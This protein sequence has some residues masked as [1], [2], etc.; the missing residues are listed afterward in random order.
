MERGIDFGPCAKD[1]SS[2][3]EVCQQANT[4]EERHFSELGDETLSQSI[5]KF[6]TLEDMRDSHAMELPSDKGQSKQGRVRPCKRKRLG[7]KNFVAQLHEQIQSDPQGFN[8][9]NIEWPSALLD[10]E[11]GRIKNKTLSNLSVYRNKLLAELSNKNAN[12]S[13]TSSVLILLM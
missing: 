4:L 9:D 10:N 2:F 8:M 7:F 12:P 11:S 13:S 6:E 1:M 3:V 5:L